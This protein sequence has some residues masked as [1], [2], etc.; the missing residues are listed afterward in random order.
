MT[1]RGPEQNQGWNRLRQAAS[2]YAVATIGG[3]SMLLVGVVLAAL[4]PIHLR[5]LGS[6]VS[7]L[8]GI[9]VS[10]SITANYTKDQAL[11]EQ[12]QQLKALS[13]YLGTA[14]SHIQQAAADANNGSISTEAALA[15]I[16]QGTSHLYAVLQHVQE[17]CG[18]RFEPEGLIDTAE[19]V[20]LL[21]SRL[22]ATFAVATTADVQEKPA[23]IE[24]IREDFSRTLSEITATIQ[25]VK[26][27][28][29][30]L[31]RTTVNCPECGFANE[32]MIGSFPGST[33]TSTCTKCATRFN[34]HRRSSG[35]LFTNRIGTALQLSVAVNCSICDFSFSVNYV[36][37]EDA[38]KRR[39]CVNCGATLW[40]KV[41]D[42][43]ISN[44]LPTK[45]NDGHAVRL[46]GGRWEVQ[47]ATCGQQRAYFYMDGAHIFSECLKCGLLVSAP[48]VEL[49]AFFP[50]TS[51]L[52]GANSPIES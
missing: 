41:P 47:C 21:T 45:I 30:A 40:I 36:V 14:S 50:L 13:Q 9:I 43:T 28:A 33:A 39:F 48:K 1:D 42:G 12:N 3:I 44:A 35:T 23:Q 37:N 16:Q 2:E 26:A 38:T 46:E 52:T 6:F 49:Q 8:G 51:S 29:G 34:I 24:A 32:T 15:L 5:I 19:T 22:A 10:W 25:S 20:N 17:L 7:G 18:T 31:E 27:G 4:E 11:H